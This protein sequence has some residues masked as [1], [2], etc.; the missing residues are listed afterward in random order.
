MNEKELEL[1]VSPEVEVLH[2][3]V[4]KGFAVSDFNNS[5]NG[6]DSQG[7]FEGSYFE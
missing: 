1:Y 2:I 7:D 3:E 4:E 6:W 5:I